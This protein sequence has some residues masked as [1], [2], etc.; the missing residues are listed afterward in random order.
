LNSEYN[1]APIENTLDQTRAN[2]KKFKASNMSPDI[3]TT[4]STSGF[5]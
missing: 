5:A 3:K 2:L 1:R 4:G